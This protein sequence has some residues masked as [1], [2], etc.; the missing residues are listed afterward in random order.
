MKVTSLKLTVF[1]LIAWAA[2][3]TGARL[4]SS[5][6]GQEQ[7][8][9]GSDIIPVERLADWRPGVT[10]GVPGGIPT[11]R[12]TLIDVTKEPYK[13]D[14]TG[15]TDA[16][17][18]IQKAIADA[19]EKEVVYL[20]AGTYRVNKPISMGYRKNITIR[21]A[22]Q[23]KTIIMAYNTYNGAV[24]M[25]GD[26][27]WTQPNRKPGFS[28]TGSPKRGDT[29][30]TVGDTSGLDAFPNGG[31]GNLGRISLK[32]DPKLPVVTVGAW[33]YARRQMSRIVAKTKTTVTISPGLLFDL[34]EPLSPRLDMSMRQAEFV[35]LEHL[36][37]DATHST[38]GRGLVYMDQCYACWL[39][40]VAVISVP[41]RNVWISDSLQCEI[42]RCY[43]AERRGAGSNGAGIQ[44]DNNASCLIED[45]IFGNQFP[46]I[47]VN[48]GATGNVFAYN[49]CVDS[50]I[51][52]MIGVSIDAN[53][54]AH[55]SY[56]LYEGNVASKFQSDGYWGSAS[57]D[58]A[59]RN[60]LHG[61]EDNCDQFGICIYLNRFTRDYNIVGN[62]LGSPKYTYL[63][64]NENR[65][66]GYNQH[67]IYVFGMPNMGNGGNDGKNVQPSKGQYW[68]DWEKLWTADPGKGPGAGG[69]QEFDMDVQ[70]TTLLKGN[71]NY[72]D[73]GVRPSESLG[74][75][76]LPNSLYLKEK[77][78][79]FGNLAWPA[80][81]PDTDFAKNKIPAQVRY[82]KIS[83]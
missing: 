69:F 47:E 57:H 9:P 82:E 45:N 59:F 33:D 23:D 14:N 21:G 58:T 78:M 75:T 83:K 76:K 30:L 70:A 5:A 1:M 62:V 81:G 48:A 20:P 12:K 19:K 17:P 42:R 49:F 28:I 67:F 29:V 34:P 71:Y 66:F 2:V 11:D 18:A 74:G 35:G 15:A 72:C 37:I 56:N 46:N 36:K 80:F 73:K 64:D 43:V 7:K 13:A 31:I 32:N 16:Q 27:D 50:T 65:G 63:Y 26:P 77:P 61:T 68:A 22:G 40:D 25:G 38:S 52:G 44:F 55:N 60:W 54:G 8:L 79:W 4:T 39:D 53:H 6:E 24:D 41:N 51:G 3:A 10:V